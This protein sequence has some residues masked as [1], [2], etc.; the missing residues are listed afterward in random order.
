MKK[1]VS[2]ILPSAIIMLFVLWS[3]ASAQTNQYKIEL[4]IKS[5]SG[6]ETKIHECFNSIANFQCS[7]VYYDCS[8]TGNYKAQARTYYGTQLLSSSSY[9]TAYPCDGDTTIDHDDTTGDTTDHEGSYGFEGKDKNGNDK[10]GKGYDSYDSAYQAA[11]AAGCIGLT[12][13][14][15]PDNSITTVDLGGGTTGTTSGTTG[16]TSGT[17]GTTSGTTFD[18]TCFLAGTKIFMSDD[19]YKNIEDIN[20]GERVASF[21]LKSKK[22]ITGTVVKTFVH[23]FNSEYLIINNK[24]KVTP[25]HLLFVNGK[26]IKAS[27]VK[28]GDKLLDN[29]GK[30]VNVLSIRTEKGT[31][32]VYNLEVDKEHNYFAENVLVHNKDVGTTDTTSGTTDTTSGT[33]DTTSGTT[34]TTSGTTDTTS[35][36]TDTT[37]GGTTMPSVD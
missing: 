34:D 37:G 11:V 5:P 7:K 13:I 20:V 26:W 14:I 6:V 36:T 4:W 35:G 12:D 1:D 21:D 24:L 15:A 31:V 30:E 8:E 2:F 29:D 19:S 32:R 18:T 25:N 28:V 16:T 9:I 17:T 22:I 10:N 33:T 27:E 23:E 3:L